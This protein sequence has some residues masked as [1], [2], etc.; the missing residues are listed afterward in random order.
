L[1]SSSVMSIPTNLSDTELAIFQNLSNPKRVD[2]HRAGPSPFPM[3]SFN[4]PPER[5]SHN[6]H[7]GEAHHHE[8]RDREPIMDM[9]DIHEDD[10]P[11]PERQRTPPSSSGRSKNRF[12]QQV[13]QQMQSHPEPARYNEP[14]Q[15][16]PNRPYPLPRK[17][18]GGRFAPGPP[19][20][21]PPQFRQPSSHHQHDPRDN[22]DRDHH[23][24]REHHRENRG[25][26]YYPECQ[27]EEEQ[28]RLKHRLIIEALDLERRGYTFAR[29]PTMEH[30]LE[31]IQF[32]VD[33]AHST[34]EMRQSVST[35]RECIPMVYGLLEG[36]NNK[37]GPFLPIQG[38]TAEFVDNMHRDP[39]KYN[40]VLERLYRRYWRKGSTSP[41]F[42]FLIVFI[43]PVV[44]FAGKRAFLGGSSQ[45]GL[46]SPVE[47]RQPVS[48][49][50][51]RRPP[52]APF[53]SPSSSSAPTST[54][55]FSSST[56]AQEPPRPEPI[57]SGHIFPPAMMN[58]PPPPVA[59]ANHPTTA[60]SS[61]G[62]RR[63]LR[64]PTHAFSPSQAPLLPVAVPVPAPVKETVA[65]TP[66][67]R[68]IPPPV[69][70]PPPL[71]APTLIATQELPPPLMNNAPM[72]IQVPSTPQK[73]APPQ[74]QMESLDLD[75]P[76]P[77]IPEG[78]ED[79]EDDTL[80]ISEEQINDFLAK[81]PRFLDEE[82][83]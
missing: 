4:V 79:D 58:Q 46:S 35:V 52:V 22:R 16:P 51:P 73:E 15:P 54:P 33:H 1:G 3:G 60:S 57:P 65:P 38:F 2:F 30:S 77:P 19:P 39:D 36:L 11:R 66:V 83:E 9:A 78:P 5:E 14:P 67:S 32:E 17:S 13:Q 44:M 80:Q 64:P 42:E 70:R 45:G 25:E 72:L 26:S 6:D 48:P 8:D 27:D 63:K 47:N 7:H 24:R 37:F 75:K 76:L 82:M 20:P 55:Q 62:G 34:I 50:A 21:P 49:E 81:N 61:G 43:F 12:A 71:P 10:P 31:E 74:E 29:K 40:H 53:S 69:T 59:M 68:A 56:Q 18:S 28:R 23:D 41:L